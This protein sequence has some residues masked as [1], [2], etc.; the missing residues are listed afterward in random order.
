MGREGCGAGI[1]LRPASGGA[2]AA[3]DDYSKLYEIRSSS[4]RPDA[5]GWGVNCGGAAP[6]PTVEWL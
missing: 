6:A 4:G 1:A 2:G 3:G 5:G